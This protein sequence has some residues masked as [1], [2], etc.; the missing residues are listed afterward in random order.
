MK[1]FIISAS[2]I[3]ITASLSAAQIEDTG[4][5]SKT[6]SKFPSFS[7]NNLNNIKI[8]VPDAVTPKV[9]I[10]VMTFS[11]Q[12]IAQTDSWINTFNTL[13]N[14]NQSV[15]YSQTA[16]IGEIPFI[17]GLIINGM[18]GSL[19]KDKWERF[20]IYTGDKEKLIKSLNV[21]N[22]A[23]FHVYVIGKDGNIKWSIKSAKA[24]DEE[25]AAMLEA[26]K[27]EMAPPVKAVK[28]GK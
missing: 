23:L 9:E 13:Y 1:K 8:T 5:N 14:G 21:E 7:A 12:D 2:L 17:G 26:V 24:S 19:A 4:L 28:K 22:P 18:K 11:R 16:V 27:K 3:F 6:A 25:I 10:A 20:L 15:T